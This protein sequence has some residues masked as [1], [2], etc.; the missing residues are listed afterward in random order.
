MLEYPQYSRPETWHGRTVPHV[1]R[2]GNHALVAR[3]RR[4]QSIL[5]TFR[6]R[7]DLYEKLDFSS[8][9]DQKLLQELM[10]EE[11]DFQPRR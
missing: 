1:L 5:R 9:E 8:K 7:P 11:A 4:K 10:E 2:S 3:W 6:R